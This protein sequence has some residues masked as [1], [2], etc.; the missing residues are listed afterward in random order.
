MILGGLTAKTNKK[1]SAPN[2]CCHQEEQVLQEKKDG[3][4]YNKISRKEV[5]LSKKVPKSSATA[6][7]TWLTV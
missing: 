1:K 7:V 6:T 4:G 5:E 2:Q 3:D